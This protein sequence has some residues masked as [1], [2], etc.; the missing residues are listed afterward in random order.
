MP[1]QPRKAM[2]S[3]QK[4]RGTHADEFHCHHYCF[5]DW[6]SRDV[7]YYLEKKMIKV[8]IKQRWLALVIIFAFAGV[9]LM[10]WNWKGGSVVLQSVSPKGING[11]AIRVLAV[12]SSANPL[13]IL[14]SSHSRFYRCEYRISRNDPLFSCQSFAEDSYI[15]EKIEVRWAGVADATVLFD[16]R[17]V[18]RCRYGW[19]EKIPTSS[20]P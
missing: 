2:F 15:A 6:S 8:K 14:T 17:P 9:T 16:D 4:A 3:F 13:W 18:L 19:W 12:P 7:G 5:S 20:V 1:F 11:P 10:W